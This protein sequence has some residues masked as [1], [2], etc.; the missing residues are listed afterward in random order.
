MLFSSITQ[1]TF[2]PQW[3]LGFHLVSQ[4]DTSIIASTIFAATT[5]WMVSWWLATL[6]CTSSVR[7]SHL[8]EF[9]TLVQISHLQSQLSYGLWADQASTIPF[10]PKWGTMISTWAN[11]GFHLPSGQRLPY[12]R[13]RR[14][15]ATSPPWPEFLPLRC[16]GE[17]LND[18][19]CQS[20]WSCSGHQGQAHHSPVSILAKL[21]AQ[22][23]YVPLALSRGRGYGEGIFLPSMHLSWLF[24]RQVLGLPCPLGLTPHWSP[25]GASCGAGPV[26][27]G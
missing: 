13:S 6:R 9:C 17:D 7:W 10:T 21:E 18:L 26:F 23:R 4:D 1:F 20:H 25:D 16:S 8:F 15:S 24:F 19:A 22:A 12:Y 14:G 27:S 3:I 2:F 5:N 11:S